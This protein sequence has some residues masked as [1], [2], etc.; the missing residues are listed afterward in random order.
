M[1][2]ANDYTVAGPAVGKVLYVELRCGFGEE[3]G[4]VDGGGDKESHGAVGA[5]HDEPNCQTEKGAAA[6][7]CNSKATCSLGSPHFCVRFEFSLTWT[8]EEKR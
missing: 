4:D 3:H 6:P 8:L 7:C 2:P 5:H 1:S